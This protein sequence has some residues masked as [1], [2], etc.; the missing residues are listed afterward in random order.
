MGVLS[1]LEPSNVLKFFEEIC[2]I[3]HG[4]GNVKQ[5]SDYLVDFAKKR[6]LRY[7]QDEKYNV[8]IWEDGSAGYENSDAVIMQGHIDMVAVKDDDCDKDMEKEGLDLE[9]NGDLISAKSTSL[10]GDDGIAVAY[11]LA[12]LDS[13]TV[14]HPPIE[15]IFTVD[16]EIGMLGADFIDVS[17]LKGRI[18]MNMDSEDEGVLTVSCAGGVGATCVFPYKTEP[19]NAP[20]IE[21]RMDGFVG[22]HSGVEIHKGRVN[23]NCA[24][25]R[26]LLNVFQSVGMRIVTVNGGDKDNAIATFSEAAIAVLPENVDKVKEI[27]NDTFETIKEEYKTVEPT[28]KIAIN[29]IEPSIVEAISN[30]STLATVI[31]LVNLP[32]GVQRMN[33]DMENMVQTSLNLGI[34]R[35]EKDAVKMSFA[36]R[37]SC[38]SEKQYLVEKLRSLTEI[39]GGE[40]E[41]EGDY[42]G[43]EYKADSK[44][45]DVMVAAYEELY[46]ET[47]VVEGIHAGL[48]CGIFASKL[49]GLDAVSF[50]PQMKDIHTTGE[51]LSISSTERTWNLLLK[52]LEL[53]K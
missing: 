35:T 22:G 28:A 7:R 25:G 14:A 40:V 32:G 52:A 41:I 21:I 19:V 44:L 34:L 2:S 11:A 42:P 53:L 6:D 36:V 46:G 48:E 8:I 15:A 27:I 50:G 3:P 17:D 26:I 16:E 51:V 12:V 49:P 18:F 43:W 23:A 4:S 45:R 29:V 9:I 20:V 13:D 5:I 10:G 30:T 31:A 39:F 47:P 24:M 1:K 33:P 38:Q 37:S